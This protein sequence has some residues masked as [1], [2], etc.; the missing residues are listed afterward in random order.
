MINKW[1]NG[2]DATSNK[3]A[4]SP[5]DDQ[6]AETSVRGKRRPRNYDDYDR[7]IQVAIVFTIK[8]ARK[9]EYHNNGYRGSS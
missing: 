6:G 2:E 4:R 5:E 9:D 7:P 3:R 8:D 1:A